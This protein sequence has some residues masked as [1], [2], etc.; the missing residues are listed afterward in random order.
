MTAVLY[1]DATKA[2]GNV[3][4]TIVATIAAPTAP[5]LSSE[6]NAAGSVN[7]SCFLFDNGSLVTANT[8]KVTA[9]ARLCTTEQFQELGNTTYEVADLQYVYD[10]Q[11]ASSTSDNKA[12]ALLLEGAEV[13]I[14]ERLGLPAGGSTPTDYAVGQYVNVYHVRLGKQNRVRQGDAEAAVFAI[15]QSAILIDPP[16]YD[17]AIVA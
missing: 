16:T 13:Y 17:V 6:I 3:S 2:Q 10:P 11:A 15:T 4:V 1:P 12:K 14:V 9:P 8:N 7:V 5:D